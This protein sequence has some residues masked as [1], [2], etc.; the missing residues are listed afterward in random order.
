MDKRKPEELVA[1][2][3][4]K[5]IADTDLVLVDVEYVKE[6]E[7]YLRVFLDKPGGVDLDDCQTVSRAL[8]EWLD[9]VDPIV[10][11]YH[12]E[13]SSPGLDRP[14]KKDADLTR[15][16]GNLIE[17]TFFGPWEGKKLW[18][19]A[20]KEFNGDVVSVEID[21]KI[22]EL[23]RKQIAQIRLHLG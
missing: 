1:E 15:N 2:Q 13:V 6:R 21:E 9:E 17:A 20:L 3:V 5:I 10:N 18:I 4:E 11:S 16:L 7:W 8:S 14:L 22:I 12:L 23:P 19:G